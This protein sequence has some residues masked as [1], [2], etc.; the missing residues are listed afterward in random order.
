[1]IFSVTKICRDK[2]DLH[3]PQS[4]NL[5]FFLSWEL[6]IITDVHSAR[7]FDK[8]LG[9]G[10]KAALQGR[11]HF[12]FLTNQNSSVLTLLYDTNA[13]IIT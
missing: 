10:L 9:F 2:M 6:D 8:K 5:F 4:Q 1:M 3:S 12:F 7:K 11:N 13:L